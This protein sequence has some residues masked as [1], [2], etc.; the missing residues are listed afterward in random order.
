MT[1]HQQFHLR[2]CS[3]FHHSH[4]RHVNRIRHGDIS[5]A[6]FGFGRCDKIGLLRRSAQLPPHM[7]TA[8]VE[9]NICPCQTVQLAHTQAGSQQNYNVIVVI[10]AAVLHELQ[11]SLLLLLSQRVTHIG[12]LRHHVRQLEFER[13]LADDVIIHRHFKRRPDNALQHTDGVLLDAAVVQEHKPA[14]CVG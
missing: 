1:V 10:S 5:D 8:P 11:V 9:I 12:I 7:D 2:G 13:I 4:Q 6:A 14:L 3:G